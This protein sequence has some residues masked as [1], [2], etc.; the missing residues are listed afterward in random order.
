MSVNNTTAVILA[1]GKGKRMKSD[2]PKVL[3][4]LDGRY[5]VDHVIEN[6]RKA[7]VE[8]IVLVV[9]HKHELVKEKLADRGIKFVIQEPQLGTGH[10]VQIAM[11]AIEGFVGDLLVLC[12]DMP[13]ITPATMTGLINK[14]RETGSAA[15]ALT[16]RLDDPG[17]YGRIVRDKDGFLKAIV[18][19]KDADEKIRLID[20]VN[21][22]AYCF[23]FSKLVPVLKLLK[24]ENAQAE[25][26]LTDTIAL[27]RTDNLKVSALISDNPNEGM[28]VNSQ[29]ELNLMESII[30]EQ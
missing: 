22:A 26:Y 17:S 5:L 11:P 18:E 25:Y 8:N 2:L 3:H 10:A 12:G 7:G 27:F 13:F 15:T 20:E 24:A 28:G 30:K 14:R 9:G 29:D 6:V 23:D 4:K 19:Y 16:V 21:T 1:A